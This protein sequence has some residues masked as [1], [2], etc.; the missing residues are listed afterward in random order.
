MYWMKNSSQCFV[1]ILHMLEHAKPEKSFCFFKWNL[2]V[3]GHCKK[4]VSFLRFIFY[5]FIFLYFKWKLNCLS[6][7]SKQLERSHILKYTNI[8]D[9]DQNYWLYNRRKKTIFRDLRDF[10]QGIILQYI[11]IY[12]NIFTSLAKNIINP[13]RLL[14][15]SIMIL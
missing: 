7:M 13:G 14:W 10:Y 11:A 6:S 3:R 4:N 8:I 5:L 1:P 15:L 9:W 12:R 2:S